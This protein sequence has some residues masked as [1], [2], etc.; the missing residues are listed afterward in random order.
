[1]SDDNSS[2]ISGGTEAEE[3]KKENL[4]EQAHEE[5]QDEGRRRIKGFK[6]IT[7]I[8]VKR[9][10]TYEFDFEK[11]VFLPRALDLSNM[12][13]TDIYPLIAHPYLTFLRLSN[14]RLTNKD[15]ENLSY[16]PKLV[17]LYLDRNEITSTTIPKL[18]YLQQLSFE[19]NPISVIEPIDQPYLQILILN[20][21]K[22]KNLQYVGI[23]STPVLLTLSASHCYLK[24]MVGDYA[25][26]MRNLYLSYN[27]IRR[28]E[29]LEGLVNLRILHLRSN[30]ISRLSGLTVGLVKLEYVNLREN[31]LTDPEELKKIQSLPSLRVLITKD[32]P[33][34]DEMGSD[35]RPMILM[36][37]L[38]IKRINKE[39]TDDEEV[40]YA[41]KLIYDLES[42]D[43]FS[44]D[45]VRFEGEE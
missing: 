1:M 5:L 4:G 33:L 32:N 3:E 15:L 43:A 12:G 7:K 29:G 13:L 41:R 23:N 38:E 31:E 24:S 45:D 2:D 10:M 20:K 22:I 9:F 30:R 18:E 40:E 14:N 28:I 21:T 27:E 42:K 25:L 17:S 6:T 44:R 35:I 16:L 8:E 26:T 34:D 39:L 36:Y 37:S 19:G 11:Q